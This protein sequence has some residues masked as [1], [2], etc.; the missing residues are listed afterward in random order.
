MSSGARRRR[1]LAL[2]ATIASFALPANAQT[3]QSP[4]PAGAPA[5][6][7]APPAAPSDRVTVVL[8]PGQR[9]LLRLAFPTFAGAA[10]LAAGAREA[11]AELERTLRDDLVASRIFEIQGPEAFGILTLS[12]EQTRDFEQYRSLGNE[13]LLASEVKLEEDKLV[14]EG[15]LFDL[16]S[17]QVIVG[18]RYR[19]TYDLARRMA[20]TF[21]DEVVLYFTGRRGVALTGITFYSDREGDK[22]IYLMDYDGHNPRKVTAHKSISMS[23][24]WSPSGDA[25]AYVS[26]FE[27]NGP[28]IFV[29][30]V[31][32][33]HKQGVQTRG[34]LSTSQSFSPDGNRL[35]FARDVG[36]NVEIFV[37]DRDG[38][39]LRQLT[40]SAGIDTN[41]SWSPSGKEIAFSSS[42]GTGSPQIYVMDA[43]GASVRRVTFSGDY[44]DGAAW[45]PDGTR[46]AYATRVGNRFAIAALDLVTLA[47][48]TLTAAEGSSETPSF[49]P[50]GRRIAFAARR[51]RATQI[52]TMDVDGSHAVQLTSEGNNYAPDWSGYL[53]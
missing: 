27:G 20:H 28:A 14:L 25:I 37:C 36:S 18:K 12:G 19:G 40:H 22:E 7:G 42:R 32:T 49:S 2:V 6:T 3:P 53:K 31:A 30:D 51:G 8:Q 34:W 45:S 48:Q 4:P 5:P 21:A 43:E 50:D 38:G 1:V 46:L 39:N 23:P 15:R 26:F 47:S 17:R 9:P 41:P 10:A 13:I 24:V 52:W 35:A 11:A 29:A 44:N 33:G 16:P